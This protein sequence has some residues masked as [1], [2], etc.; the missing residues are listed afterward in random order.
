MTILYIT[1]LLA[2]IYDA[3]K[4]CV[5]PISPCWNAS[6]IVSAVFGI[7]WLAVGF[8]EATPRQPIGG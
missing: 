5:L 3:L 8:S 4:P 1:Q 7:L 2:A 6:P